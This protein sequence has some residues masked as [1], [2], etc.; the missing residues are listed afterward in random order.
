ARLFLDGVF[1]YHGLPETI[2]SDRDPRFTSAFWKT[3][4]HLLG[5]HC[6]CPRPTARKRT[7]R[8]SASIASS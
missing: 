8:R 4:F 5:T 6:S 3:L 7:A 2:I 1:R